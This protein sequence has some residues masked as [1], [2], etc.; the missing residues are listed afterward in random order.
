MEFVSRVFLDSV[1]ETG[2]VFGPVA[3]LEVSCSE[4][5]CLDRSI[6]RT[7]NPRLPEKVERRTFN[8]PAEGSNPSRPDLHLFTVAGF[9]FRLRG[10]GQDV[11]GHHNRPDFSQASSFQFIKLI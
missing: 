1:F 9:L 3:Q 5:L 10:F 4:V 8:P 11:A 7:R 2:N 6:R